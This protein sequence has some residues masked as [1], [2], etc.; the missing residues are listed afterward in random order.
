MSDAIDYLMQ[1]RPKAMQ[2]YFAFLRQSGR[3]LDPRT[4]ALISVI[5]KVAART[6]RGFRQYL[7]RALRAGCSA[8]EI[9]DALLAAFPII[10]LTGLT[11]AVDI[12]LEM[13]IPEFRPEMLGR[14]PVWHDVVAL[15]ELS[16]GVTRL[17]CDGRELFI[18]R[19]GEAIAVYDSRCPHQV[20]NIPQ[21]ALDG[22]TL[23]CP[24][25][26][27]QFDV[28]DGS[29]IAKGDRPLTQFD[30]RVEEGRLQVYW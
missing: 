3:S 14:Q 30:H 28:R 8:E 29:C 27:W 4:R 21:L 15:N 5:T 20:T 24:K 7:V 16:D 2:S 1:A 6:D 9:L 13:D 18:R 23:T 22:D 11:W 10:G 12:I 17:A 26:G 19:E 25:H